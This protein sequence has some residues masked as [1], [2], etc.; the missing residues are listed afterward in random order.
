MHKTCESTTGVVHE[1]KWILPKIRILAAVAEV[2]FLLSII[3]LVSVF[4]MREMCSLRNP[5]KKNL[6]R[7]ISLKSMY[8]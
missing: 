1:H 7:A 2:L 3:F 5:V 4:H 8:S 6:S